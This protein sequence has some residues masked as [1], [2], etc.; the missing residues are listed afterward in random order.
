MTLGFHSVGL[1]FDSGT[2]SSGRSNYTRR[3]WGF[4]LGALRGV[5]A[6]GFVQKGMIVGVRSKKLDITEAVATLPGQ[7]GDQDCNLTATIP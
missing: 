2:D 5:N 4:G 3:F 7:D 1:G 6:A